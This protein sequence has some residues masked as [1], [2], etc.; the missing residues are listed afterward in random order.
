MFILKSESEKNL[1]VH[2]CE[3][4]ITFYFVITEAPILIIMKGHLNK[5]FNGLFEVDIMHIGET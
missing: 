4:A 2:V 3:L 5:L 1:I